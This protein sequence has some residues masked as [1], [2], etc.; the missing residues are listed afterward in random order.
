MTSNI[1]ASP[2]KH[3]GLFLGSFKIK[4]QISKEATYDILPNYK[5]A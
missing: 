2:K 1:V 5:K 4:K 3:Q